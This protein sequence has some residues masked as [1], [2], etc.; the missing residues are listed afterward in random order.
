MFPEQFF[1]MEPN[2]FQEIVQILG[3]KTKEK[4]GTERLL[5]NTQPECTHANDTSFHQET[6]PLAG[7]GN[8]SPVISGE[9]CPRLYSASSASQARNSK[10]WTQEEDTF[11]TGIIM[12]TYRRRH[13][14]RPCRE[15]KHSTATGRNS[16]T[17]VWS[18]IA[19][20]YEIARQR[21]HLM[22]GHKLPQRTVRA[23]EKRWKL[24][25]QQKED[26]V[27]EHGC[28]VQNTCSSRTLEVL[29]YTRY[30]VDFILTCPEEDF[31]QQMGKTSNK[32]ASRC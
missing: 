9:T 16:S 8:R 18:G 27:D 5:A 4:H 21:Y 22:S 2:A 6:D 19:R 17:V 31:L 30:N 14:L 7:K 23:L 24:S 26:D 32:D 10:C 25:S 13:S 11:L 15:D 1:D 29:W 28:V 20:R 3:E 12:D